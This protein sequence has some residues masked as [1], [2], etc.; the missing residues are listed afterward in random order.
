MIRELEQLAENMAHVETPEERV[1][2]GKRFDQLQREIERRQAYE[3][4][5]RIER[6]LSGLGFPKD[7][8]SKPIVQLSGGQQNRLLLARL[9][10]QQPD[11]ML[12]DEPSN[13]LDIEATEWLESFLIESNQALLLV[14]HDRYLLDRVATR[15]MELLHG[16][17]DSFPGN[18]SAYRVQK[19]GTFG[20]AAADVREATDRNRQDGRFRPAELLRPKTCTGR[21]PPEETR[22]DRASQPP[23][24]DPT[25]PMA[26]PPASRTGD[27]VLRVEGLAK[28]FR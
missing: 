12:L 6:V 23:P 21:R 15:T 13:H 20:G 5:H 22:A 18:Y 1:R 19:G 2:L 14:S 8:F 25:P 4:D 9:L 27:I 24:R 7:A 10:L 11:V 17:V 3:L 16:E 28:G 26:F